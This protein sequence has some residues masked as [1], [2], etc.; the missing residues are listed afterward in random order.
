MHL[1]ILFLTSSVSTIITDELNK[2]HWG[3]S[4]AMAWIYVAVIILILIVLGTF[5]K[6]LKI[7]ESHYEN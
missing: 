6:L 4:S 3:V 7:G 1:W 2:Q 5:A